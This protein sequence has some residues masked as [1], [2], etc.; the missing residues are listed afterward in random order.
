MLERAE[1][2][3]LEQY[4][5]EKEAYRRQCDLAR[6]NGHEGEFQAFD[7]IE[8]KKILQMAAA[9]ATTLK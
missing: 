6:A 7:A 2:L 1:K 8:Y 5:L 3:A 9:G 4:E